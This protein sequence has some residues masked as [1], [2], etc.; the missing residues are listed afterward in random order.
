LNLRRLLAEAQI[1]V[2]DFDGAAKQLARARE[3]ISASGKSDPRVELEIAANEAIAGS[4]SGKAQ[5]IDALQAACDKAERDLGRDDE[6]TLSVKNELAGA[7]ANS[8]LEA[9]LEQ[10]LKVLDTAERLYRQVLETRTRL[11]GESNEQTLETR[12]KLAEVP[13]ARGEVKR[14][15]IPR[16][17]TDQQ[18]RQLDFDAQ[19]DF[20]TAL[21][22]MSA[23]AE[24]AAAARGADAIQTIEARAEVAK[25]Y[26]RLRRIADADRAYSELIEPMCRRL[27]PDHWRTREI[28]ESWYALHPPARAPEQARNADQ[29]VLAVLLTRGSTDPQEQA[30]RAVLGRLAANALA[31]S[32]EK[33]AKPREAR[34]WLE[35]AYAD[36]LVRGA[37]GD[38]LEK[39]SRLIDEFRTRNPDKAH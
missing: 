7:H 37:A 8:H 2:G 34:A 25:L 13:I 28:L 21:K 9:G 33:L 39:Q 38:E 23:A 12:I 24:A 26:H 4:R 11:L 14:R 10:R 29:T 3:L 17:N 5:P 32:L 35:W 16:A 36:L 20:A 1:K 19:A 31:T 30:A 15:A 6:L 27:G 22:D 18:R